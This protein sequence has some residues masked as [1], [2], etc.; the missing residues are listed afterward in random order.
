MLIAY[1]SQT[2]NAKCIAQD[3]YE[4]CQQEGIASFV[5]P[6]NDWKK[7]KETPIDKVKTAVFVV[8]TTGNGE[9]P[10]NCDRFRSFIR[11]RSNATDMLKHL[12]FAVLG[13]GDTNYDQFCAT[14][15]FFNKRL[16][17]LGATPF[18]EM[19]CAD[20]ATGLEDVVEPWCSELLPKLRAVLNHA[21]EECPGSSG[22][23]GNT[24][25]SSDAATTVCP[26]GARAACGCFSSTKSSLCETRRIAPLDA[27]KVDAL[28]APP[29]NRLAKVKG[30]C[31]YK[32]VYGKAVAAG[33]DE[34]NHHQ[35]DHDEDAPVFEGS[36]AVKAH[37]Y[38]TAGDAKAERRVVELELEVMA[39]GSSWEY[40]AGDAIGVCVRNH[41]EDVDSTLRA[42]ARGKCR[43]NTPVA[44]EEGF[45]ADRPFTLMNARDGSL[46]PQPV[47]PKG[48]RFQCTPRM[49][50]THCVDLSGPIKPAVL[51][52]LAYVCDDER[53]AKALSLLGSCTPEG[54]ALFN[55]FV[56]AQSLKFCEVLEL[57]PSVKPT[58]GL[59][60]GA[61]PPLACRYYSVASSPLCCG[62]SRLK[63]AFS[64]VQW[65]SNA[66][67][68]NGLCT[69]WL[70]RT[71]C[72]KKGPPL[73]LQVVSKPSTDFV[74]PRYASKPV[75]MIGPGTGVAPFVGFLEQRKHEALHP[76]AGK[77]LGDTALYFGCRH[78]AQDWIFEDEMK[79]F[80]ETGVLTKL[81]TAFSR[82]QEHKVYVQ[83]LMLEDAEDIFDAIVRRDG[84]VFVCGDGMHMAKDVRSALL[85]ILSRK[86]DEFPTTEAAE[87]FL[88]EMK[89]ASRYV[90]DIWG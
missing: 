28:P 65:E 73:R 29:A 72:D 39:G 8:S 1:G 55:E 10:D 38:L 90:C 81:R 82:E 58:L 3:I 50:L 34:E 69:T 57:F 11:R 54:K 32:A 19:G 52:A 42:L 20:E 33:R 80:V 79:A 53:D 7:W 76:K 49:V 36:A 15:K 12:K 77:T 40:K 88:T 86:K 85:D 17:E 46:A 22:S 16:K 6:L 78:R 9:A 45:D 64:V 30:M 68:R 26:G 43:E 27:A 56:V 47:G 89:E 21:S 71:L 51:G 83:H 87:G 5:G 67:P 66:V 84:Y 13:L 37:R 23:S 74:M 70:E 24:S 60:L 35:H 4:Q 75:I 14:G 25:S 18:H 44:V 2:G 31:V 63:V 61:L 41:C 59:L 62:A 48:V